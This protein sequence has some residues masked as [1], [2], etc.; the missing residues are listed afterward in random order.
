MFHA[1]TLC[2]SEQQMLM[3]GSPALQLFTAVNLSYELS[4][5]NEMSW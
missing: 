5:W 2:Q 4:W 1:L 3:L